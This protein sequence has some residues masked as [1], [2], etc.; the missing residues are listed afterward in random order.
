MS[1]HGESTVGLRGR[2]TGRSAMCGTRVAEPCGLPDWF[3]RNLDTGSGIIHPRPTPKVIDVH[4]A[5]VVHVDQRAPF[6]C[7]RREVEPCQ[8][9]SANSRT[10]SL[11]T[12]WHDEPLRVAQRR[13]PMRNTPRRCRGLVENGTP[14][15]VARP[16]S[17][18]P[19]S[20]MSERAHAGR[21][22]AVMETWPTGGVAHA[23]RI[24]A[25]RI[26]GLWRPLRSCRARRVC[27]RSRAPAS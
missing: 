17:P 10:G 24:R 25:R 15:S 11:C 23:S 20:Q 14:V 4:D 26:L 7:L 5:L 13:I 6:E 19:P 9:S 27:G 21:G 18:S 3:A 22:A 1:T 2:R 12:S 16:S 8:A